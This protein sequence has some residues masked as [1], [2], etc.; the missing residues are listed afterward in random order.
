MDN[1]ERAFLESGESSNLNRGLLQLRPANW[2]LP[3]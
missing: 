2:N 3:I 1:D